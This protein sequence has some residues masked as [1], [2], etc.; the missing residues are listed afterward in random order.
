MVA[1]LQETH[2]LERLALMGR[3]KAVHLD[4][5]RAVVMVRVFPPVGG[6]PGWPRNVVALRPVAYSVARSMRGLIK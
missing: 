3:A 5:K 4:M 2:H 1:P 6:A